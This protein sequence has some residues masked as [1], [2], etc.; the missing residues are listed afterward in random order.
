MRK[1]LRKLREMA[2]K[3]TSREPNNTTLRRKWP[4]KPV[5]AKVKTLYAKARESHCERTVGLE[6][7]RICAFDE[8][9]VS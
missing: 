9:H 3:N 6:H 1:L 4:R 7:G 2:F 8:G 5:R